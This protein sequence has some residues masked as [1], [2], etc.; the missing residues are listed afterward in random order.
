MGFLHVYTGNGKGKTTASIG[1]AI[2]FLGSGGDVIL[3]QFLKGRLSGEVS[4]LEE[5]KKVKIFRLSKDYGFTFSMNEKVKKLVK[6]EHNE[7]LKNA[8]KEVKKTKESNRCLLILDECAGAISE[9]LLEEADILDI[10]K[11]EN[12]GLELVLTGRSFSKKILEKADYIS[13]IRSVRHPM[14]IGLAAREGIEF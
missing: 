14:E 4:F 8:L 11:K 7:I 10:I 2:R 1:I 9:G 5:V 3:V 6:E 13:D 12:R